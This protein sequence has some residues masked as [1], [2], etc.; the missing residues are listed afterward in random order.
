[1]SAVQKRRLAFDGCLPCRRRKK[2]CDLRKP[3]CLGCERNVLICSWI[4]APSRETHSTHFGKKSFKSTIKVPDSSN[5]VVQCRQPSSVASCVLKSPLAFFLYQHWLER[6]GNTMSAQRGQLNS[7]ITVLPRLALNYPDTILQSLLALSGV[8]YANRN[9]NAQVSVETWTRLGL[10]LRALKHGLTAHATPQK[11]IDPVPLLTTT[12]VLCFIETTRGDRGS[13]LLHHLEAAR[14][15]LGQLLSSSVLSLI[16]DDVVEFL[17]EFYVYVEGITTLTGPSTEDRTSLL[18]GAE[19]DSTYTI[20]Q[21]SSKSP[22]NL[23]GCSQELF[24]IIPEVQML[25]QRCQR[26]STEALNPTGSTDTSVVVELD[27]EYQELHNRISTWLPPLSASPDFAACALMYQEAVLCHLETAFLP[28][29][30]S[31]SLIRSRLLHFISLLAT[32]PVDSPISATL[33]WPL[34]G[35]G[36]LSM[37]HSHRETI[38]ERLSNMWDHLRLKNIEVSMTFLRR[39]WMEDPVSLSD[40]VKTPCT[41]EVDL[42][43][44][45]RKMSVDITFV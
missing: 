13:N 40:G 28:S 19:F 23:L 6:T 38:Y 12:L 24:N 43:S 15:L 31:H 29:S 26:Q 2:R 44:I 14:F 39:L 22:G 33:T 34:V 8:H 17:K 18:P 21:L 5:A 16:E 27:D 7:F 11:S 3:T 20:P 35:F 36:V 25:A 32:L 37:D 30:W 1:M 9:P 42:G 10:T 41:L 45:M 4:N